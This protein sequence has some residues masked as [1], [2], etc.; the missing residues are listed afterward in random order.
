MVGNYLRLLNEGAVL[1]AA[2]ESC[3][4]GH[5]SDLILRCRFSVVS[6]VVWVDDHWAVGNVWE[7]IS[8][9]DCCDKFLGRSLSPRYGDPKWLWVGF[10]LGKFS[11]LGGGW[12]LEVVVDLLS[13]GLVLVGQFGR[14]RRR[15]RRTRKR[16]IL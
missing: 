13:Y 9:P 11:S 7:V 3:L 2:F 16:E 14:G 10:D 15:V 1:N 12:G 6:R 8:S 4:S 5:K